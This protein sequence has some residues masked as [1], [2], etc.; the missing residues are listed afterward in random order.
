VAEK[1]IDGE[2]T[3]GAGGDG[4]SAWQTRQQM[5]AL[6]RTGPRQRHPSTRSWWAATREKRSQFDSLSTS[7]STPLGFRAVRCFM[8]Y[9]VEESYA[10]TSYLLS[11][12]DGDSRELTRSLEC[13]RELECPAKMS[14]DHV[15]WQVLCPA[16]ISGSGRVLILLPLP[17]PTRSLRFNTLSYTFHGVSP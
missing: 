9:I 4:G 12:P 6:L 16:G 8:A 17:P 7:S 3:V 1:G 2:N 15:R 10:I 5:E 14:G 11:L 13:I